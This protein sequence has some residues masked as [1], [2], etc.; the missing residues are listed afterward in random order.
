MDLFVPN[1]RSIPALQKELP[2][3]FP[4]E[5]TTA[6]PDGP[7][8]EA[9][10]AP[11]LDV[12]KFRSGAIHE[13]TDERRKA[14]D[15]ILTRGSSSVAQTSIVDTSV[16]KAIHEQQETNL[17]KE[18]ETRY[19]GA[20]LTENDV[21]EIFAQRPKRAL[22]SN[23]NFTFIANSSAEPTIL[24][25]HYGVTGKTIRD[26][27]NRNTWFRTTRHLWTVEELASAGEKTSD[28]QVT[29]AT[30]RK[31]GRPSGAKDALPRTRACRR[32]NEPLSAEKDSVK[33]HAAVLSNSVSTH[34]PASCAQSNLVEAAVE[35][36]Q[37]LSTREEPA[38]L[39]LQPAIYD[40]NQLAAWIN[41]APKPLLCAQVA[42]SLP[43]STSHGFTSHPASGLTLGSPFCHGLAAGTQLGG[44]QLVGVNLP[45]GLG[46]SF[47]AQSF[48]ALSGLVSGTHLAMPFGAQPSQAPLVN[49][50]DNSTNGFSSSGLCLV[51]NNTSVASVDASAAPKNVHSVQRL[52]VVA[53]WVEEA[54]RS[55]H[56]LV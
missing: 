11:S 36:A 52:P 14:N 7:F 42:Q 38:G 55:F 39:T 17:P 4:A 43:T 30:K 23:G 26:I 31:R 28:D 37:Q 10:S 44:N 49:A 56:T 45:G 34:Q 41:S 32:K 8:S 16:F 29:P 5:F 51:N 25:Q 40:A 33:T 50:L 27:W 54:L 12:L 9:R 22:D 13:L 1:S 35:A 19:H 53:P 20:V 15:Q 18:G 24:A 6:P 3:A 21:L 47:G 46:L 2:I 48:Q